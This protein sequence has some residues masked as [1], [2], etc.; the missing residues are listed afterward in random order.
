VLTQYNPTTLGTSITIPNVI[1]GYLISGLG[2]QVF[3][4]RKELKEVNFSEGLR[5][6]GVKAFANCE[7]LEKLGNFPKTLRYIGDYAFYDCSKLT[8]NIEFTDNMQSVGTQAF[9]G[10]SN[11]TGTIT[12]LLRTNVIY[13]QNVFSG[14][15]KITGD[16]GEAMSVLIKSTDT[17]I[18]DNLFSGM[19]G[20]TGTV[21]IGS[22]I[23][24]IGKMAFKGCQN[25]TR[26]D[27]NQASNL[28][29]IGDYAFYG[30]SN[31]SCELNFKDGIRKI[32]VSAFNWC[33]ISYLNIP[34]T[35]E[36]VGSSAFRYAYGTSVNL[37]C[38]DVFSDRAF[39][40][41]KFTT[42]TF[43]SDCT[44]TYIP[45]SMFAYGC[46]SNI[47]FPNTITEIETW[48]FSSNG[49]LTTVEF[50]NNL[51]YIRYGAFG[52]CPKLT[53]IPIDSEKSLIEIG[54]MAF[55]DCKNLGKNLEAKTNLISLLENSNVTTIGE[56]A[57][58]NC[59]YLEGTYYAGLTNKVVDEVGNHTI[60]I[61]VGT[62]AFNGT[63][64]IYSKVFELS[65]SQEIL[66]NEFENVSE[67]TDSSKN[68]IT[69]I[70]IPSTVKTIGA[71]AFAN[72]S[73][74]TKIIIPDS[75]TIID[76]SAFAYC[77]S[78]TTVINNSKCTIISSKMFYGCTALTTISSLEK[79]EE[80]Q[81][82]AFENCAALTLVTFGSKLNTLGNSAFMNT[83]IESVKFPKSL[84]TVGTKVFYNCK[85]LVDIDFSDY[86]L[87]SIEYGMFG[88]CSAL[89][90]INYGENITSIG[91]YAFTECSAL[92][93]IDL[94]NIEKIGE[95][96]FK[97][98]GFTSVTISDKVT[99]IGD[100][101]FYG[102]SSLVNVYGCKNVIS[103]G[104]QTFYGC[105]NLE[106]VER[107][108]KYYKYSRICVL[109]LF[110]INFK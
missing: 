108:N 23:E 40:D 21:T 59:A 76:E 94:K 89:T 32:G 13:G 37:N 48:A 3:M 20:L 4:D 58:K 91:Q 18:P 29:T 95:W 28:E 54:T 68:K 107:I 25:I 103:L 92:T 27:I 50:N 5:T 12:N 34:K 77:T 33:I 17:K 71:R 16:I 56:N 44:M 73:S 38:G 24:E 100:G 14:C 19:T 74:I 97:N 45:N 11:I 47:I 26:L 78:L 6:I 36:E 64:I 109:Q 39:F 60:V 65:N 110:K 55:S 85:K 98:C 31:M 8:T 42:L 90:S 7:N 46:L 81:L 84:T 43:G 75:V 101:V 61:S 30:C 87:N 69:E 99:I 82:S 86:S 41:S 66:A 2:D 15:S 51:K 96:A 10:C 62:N 83:S 79:I 22:T 102:D 9:Y 72:C 104:K 1:D 106:T 53:S 67:F 80:I 35:V 105:S 88:C 93:S 57:F 70:T 49:N 52:S 63:S